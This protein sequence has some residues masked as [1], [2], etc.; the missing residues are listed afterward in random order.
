MRK[1]NTQ[2]YQTKNSR[3]QSFKDFNDKIGCEES[4]LSKMNRN[5]LSNEDDV[6][7]LPNEKRLKFNKVTYKMDD[8]SKEEVKDKLKAIKNFEGYTGS[9]GYNNNEFTVKNQI[10]DEFDQ[11]EFD[12]EEF[13]ELDDYSFADEIDG[14]DISRYQ[15]EIAFENSN[16][17]SYMFFNNLKTI[18]SQTSEMINMNQKEVN[19]LLNKGHNWAEDHMSTAKETISHVYNFLKNDI[20]ENANNYMFFGN[21]K[22]INKMVRELI[23]MDQ[24]HIDNILSDEH[25]WAEDHIA[26]AKENIQQVY[27]LLKSK[28]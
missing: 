27:E 24:N 19:S 25:D 5:A 23:S 14:G 9:F 21:I 4:E 10:E 6:Y 17:T 26:T 28:I 11:D 7:D 3:I 18:A 16:E 20:N 15:D 1:D 8:I 2:N 22:L 13:E 12:D